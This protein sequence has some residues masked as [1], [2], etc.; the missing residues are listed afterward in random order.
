MT[1]KAMNNSLLAEVLT[2]LRLPLLW[3]LLL[4]LLSSCSSQPISNQRPEKIASPSDQI[5]LLLSEAARLTSPQRERNRLKAAKIMTNEQQYELAEQIATTMDPESLRLTELAIY[6][7]VMSRFHIYKGNFSEALIMVDHHRL[8]DHSDELSELKQV[9]LSLLR[10][11]ILAL[12]GDHMASAQQ[13]IFISALLNNQQQ[14]RNQKAI[15]RSLMQ[16][17]AS[18]LNMYRSKSFSEQYR[19]WLELAVIAKGQQGDLDKQ[20]QLLENWQQQWAG[21]PASKTLPGGLELLREIAANRPEHIALMLPLTGKLASLGKAVRDGFIASLY[22]TRNRG[23]KVPELKIY[24]TEEEDFIISYQKAISD[25][26]QL[27]VGPLEKHHVRMLFDEE[28]TVP[29]LALNRID[30]YGS[31]PKQLFQFGLTPED[32]AVQVAEMGFVENHRNVMII[33]P[34]GEWGTRVS[35]AF[36]DQWLQMGGKIVAH[37]QYSGQKDYSTAI[38]KSLLLTSSEARAKRIAKLIGERPEFNPRRREDVDMIFLLAR[39]QHAR[40]IKPLLAYHYAGD[41]PVYG[42]SH[43]YTGV[44]DPVKDR[45]INGIRFTDMPWILSD[46]ATF[47]EKIEQNSSAGKQFPRMVAMGIDSFQLHPRLRQLSEIPS[48]RV[49]GRTGTLKL[50]QNQQIERQMLVAQFKNNTPKIV[51]VAKQSKIV[52]PSGD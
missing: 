28:I 36:I 51:P 34:Q 5:Q 12:L 50:N 26:A 17:S 29:T 9:A 1:N 8:L 21:H 31:P 14:V 16:V 38:K 7:H 52:S 20:L 40:S 4:I 46:D 13:R 49:F 10:A 27:I 37:S 22:E 41:I 3:A 33:S 35:T 43:L 44:S 2:Q 19:G 48:S 39:P 23:G 18:E 6:V 47:R 24:N 42:T 30:D 45:D 15:W 25:G 11:E 32:E